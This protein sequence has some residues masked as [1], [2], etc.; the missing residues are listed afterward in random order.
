MARYSLGLAIAS[1]A[2]MQPSLSDV[3]VDV[4]IRLGNLPLW[5]TGSYAI[6][7]KAVVGLRFE[8]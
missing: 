2:I 3:V 8:F 6:Q 5:L 1:T 7:G 4:G